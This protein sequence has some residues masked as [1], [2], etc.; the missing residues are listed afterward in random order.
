MKRIQIFLILIV[1]GFSL[2]SQVKNKGIPF[3]KNYSPN[4]YK[5]GTSNWAIIQDNRGIMYFGNSSGILEF[6]GTSWNMIAKGVS[7]ITFEKDKE[8]KIYVG[9]RHD[10]GYLTPNQKG[11]MSFVSLKDKVP[12]EYKGMSNCWNIAITDNEVIY[13]LSDGVIFIYSNDSV[14]VKKFGTWGGVVGYFNEKVFYESGNGLTVFDEDTIKLVD[15]GELLDGLNIRNIFEYGQDSLLIITRT[16]GFYFYD[17]KTVTEWNPPAL[18]FLT[19]NQVYLASQINDNFYALGTVTAGVV[20]MNKKGEVYQHV[21]QEGGMQSNDHCAIYTDMNGNVWS[22]LEYGITNIFVNSPFSQ[23]NNQTDFPNATVYKM[24]L[25]DGNFFA[26][27]TQGIF[28]RVWNDFENPISEEWKFQLIE[29]NSGRK[30]WDLAYSDGDILSGSSN[31]GS[32]S[33]SNGKTEEIYYL[34]M[35]RFL[36]LKNGK[37][38]AAIEH[39]RGLVMMEKSN[40]KWL[41]KKLTDTLDIYSMEEDNN[42]N[43]W[44]FI[45]DKIL[46]LS[47][48]ENYDSIANIKIYDS[49][50]GVPKEIYLWT[51]KLGD[52]VLFGSV[53]GTYKIENE[54]LVLY[55]ELNQALGDSMS[56]FQISKDRNGKNWYWATQGKIETIGTIS[57]TGESFDVTIIQNPLLKLENTINN[58]FLPVDDKNLFFGTGNNIIHLDLSK[59]EVCESTFQTLLRKIEVFGPK[60]SL[61]FGGVFLDDGQIVS[62]QPEN[63]SLVFPFAYN[64]IK[65]DYSAIFYEDIDKIEYSYR[66]VGFDDNWSDWSNKAEKE[67]TYLPSGKY[68][69][70]VKAKN[71][72]DVESSIATYCFVISPPWY[73]T[74]MAFIGY[75]LL[76]I[77]IVSA[78]V[79]LSIRKVEQENIKLE[80]MVKER[81]AEITQQK[82]EIQTQKEEIEAQRDLLVDKN[83]FI[84]KQN[85]NI[86]S[87]IQYASRIQ[88]ALLPSRDDFGDLF[89]D[90]FVFY[91]PRDIVSGDFFWLKK[92]EHYILLAVADCTGHGVPGA[93]MSMLGIA[94]LNEI[95]TRREITK[96]S[97]VLEELRMQVKK[98]LKQTGDI[99]EAK[100]GMDIAFLTIDTKEMEFQFSGAHNPLYLIRNEEFVSYKGDSQP[101]AIH[102]KE[103]P[104]TNHQ[105]KIEKGDTI[106]MF[107]DG[108]I[109]QFGGEKYEKFMSKNFRKMIVENHKKPMSVQRQKLEI[110][111]DDWIN[112]YPVVKNKKKQVDDILVIGVKI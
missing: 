78:I 97:E 66:L 49:L 29:E 89:A 110:T 33:T 13:S 39:S 24:L 69:F 87:S 42:G 26:A 30:I 77:L 25:V 20:I 10:I 75:A 37:V 19:K 90:Y 21:N 93:F 7:A 102:P 65:F 57:K 8:G 16:N 112:A 11:I 60:D 91:K 80:A 108:Y 98:S 100:D 76:L 79:K 15:G 107:S 82:E 109:D 70:E 6:D 59:S 83:V 61:I 22:G 31:L 28:F 94:Y 86:T 43:V 111:L 4:D 47:F 96:A 99:N 45:D 27:T 5:A 105:Y 40:N 36:E 72:Y 38:L 84:E 44:T 54:K 17:Y 34:A 9:C 103:K 63:Q 62:Q 50:A 104:F 67:F 32:F 71:L 56:I 41:V 68:T 55:K 12:E 35:L 48:D 23:Y 14:S 51:F 74:T 1:L 106:Y 52:E 88:Q 46:K 64:A 3:V 101:I 85:E 92:L 73:K 2:F 53:N 95:V 58:S 81:T 18:E